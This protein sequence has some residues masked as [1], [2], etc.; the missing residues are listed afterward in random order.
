MKSETVARGN[1]NIEYYLK[2]DFFSYQKKI[3]LTINSNLKTQR[4]NLPIKKY[5]SLKAYTWKKQIKIFEDFYPELYAK[6]FTYEDRLVL[7]ESSLQK[8]EQKPIESSNVSIIIPTRDNIYLLRKC[9]ES[10]LLKTSYLNY[11]IFI[12]NNQSKE[13]ET[14][15]YFEFLRLNNIAKVYD[16]SLPFNYSAIHNW[17]M[18]KIVTDYVLFLNDDTEIITDSWLSR[19]LVNFNRGQIGAVGSLLLYPDMTVQHDGIYYGKYNGKTYTNHINKNLHIDDDIVYMPKKKK[20]VSGVTGACLLIPTS[21]YH[22]CGGMDER[23]FPIAFNDVDLCFKIIDKGFKIIQDS[24]V[25]LFHHESKSRGNINSIRNARR[26]AKEYKAFLKKWNLR[27]S[28]GD[29]YCPSF[30]QCY[31]GR[32][33]LSLL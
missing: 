10:I 9:I 14:Y 19:L 2:H 1:K 8:I 32:P 31:N 18:T 21:I 16:Y 7:K 13:R 4:Y 3:E 29:I 6:Y 27:L 11:Q 17:I 22:L 26:E 20:Y 25:K 24:T 12:I 33:V 30:Y 28:K 23:L 5:K 15:E